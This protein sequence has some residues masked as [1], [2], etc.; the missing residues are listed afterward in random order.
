[1]STVE[2]EMNKDEV[3]EYDFTILEQLVD[4]GNPLWVDDVV[5][6]ERMRKQLTNMKKKGKYQIKKTV[7]ILKERK[8]Y[9]EKILKWTEIEI[10]PKIYLFG[11][12]SL[13]RIFSFQKWLLYLPNLGY[14]ERIA[15]F[16]LSKS[17]TFDEDTNN[18]SKSES[19]IKETAM[20]K[21]DID[22]LVNSYLSLIVNL[23]VIGAL[24]LSLLFQFTV[25]DFTPSM[26]STDYFGEYYVTILKYIFITIINIS[27]GLSL[28][29]IYRSVFYYKQLGFWMT[30]PRAKLIWI[31]RS[32]IVSLVGSAQIVIISAVISIP[33]GA[34]SAISPV[35]GLISLI[36]MS[37]IMLI[38]LIVTEEEI[39]SI[40]IVHEECCDEFKKT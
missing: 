23:G 37:L 31:E 32:S 29:V 25:V 7:R 18:N 40:G 9:K 38:F 24:I 12:I 30:T 28:S 2:I 35:A 11:L 10:P 26:S 13:P 20:N 22:L 36:V 27:V 33:F 8:E 14:P 15:T 6:K 39:G 21:E 17:I 3:I 19:E 4:E 16:L 1:M 34:A 5:E